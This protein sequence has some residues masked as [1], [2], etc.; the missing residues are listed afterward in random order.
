M[1]KIENAPLAAFAL[2]TIVDELATLKA[3]IAPMQAR[4]KE[5]VDMLKATG[6]DRIAGT[7]HD[8]VISLSER[9]DL[10]TKK[11]KE[12]LGDALAPYF[13]AATTVTTCKV[14]ARKT[15]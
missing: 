6:M 13:K 14:T 7:Q 2:V 9:R 3:A 10:D 4:E 5:L 11:L 15:H 12:D 1:S 8:A